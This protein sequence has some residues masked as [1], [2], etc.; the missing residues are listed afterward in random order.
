MRCAQATAL[1][2]PSP[3]FLL[4]F[5]FSHF[6]MDG[7]E[8]LPY[9]HLS[10]G[11]DSQPPS[12]SQSQFLLSP[13]NLGAKIRYGSENRHSFTVN[14]AVEKQRRWNPLCFR[15]IYSIGLVGT[16]VVLA[17]LM[18]VLLAISV[19]N[20]GFQNKLVQSG[21]LKVVHFFYTAVVVALSLPVTA[22]FG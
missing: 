10:K 15:D 12:Q 16:M 20:H 9:E 14:E 13:V 5:P 17:V 3:L 6:E 22:A 19:E 4:I 2:L 21:N 7:V 11:E 1:Q 8:I 18:E